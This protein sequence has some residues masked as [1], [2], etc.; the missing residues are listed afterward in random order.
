[1]F[2]NIK[3]EIMKRVLNFKA[4]LAFAFSMLIAG[5]L[6]AQTPIPGYSDGAGGDNYDLAGAAYVTV[7][8][9]I[10][11]YASPDPYFHPAYDP[12][13]GLGLTAGFTWVWSVSV[14]PL[15][16]TLGGTAVNYT[17]ATGNNAG[18]NSTVH[19]VETPPVAWGTCVDAGTNM[20]VNVVAAPSIAY[21]GGLLPS[22]N[23][24]AGDPSLPVAIGT[25]ISGGYQNYRLEWTLVIKTLNA[26]L[27]DNDFYDTDKT[28]TPVP[29]A[30]N[31]TWL[32]PQAVAASGAHNITSVAGG[33]TI[34]D[35]STTVYTYTLNGIN[36]QASRFGDFLTLAAGAGVN[37]ALPN[38]FMH[39][40]TVADVITITVHPAPATGPIYHIVGTWA[41]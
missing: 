37:G 25:V 32:A 34:I 3:Q 6:F 9:T 39:Y 24:C 28:T 40:D 19:V 23:V 38:A 1:L 7:G 13:T 2:N 22:Y 30:E 11:L 14:N 21:A 4:I 16:I 8:K 36:D 5:G 41:L 31:Y 12:A 20:T 15:N 17:Q 10:P 26:D 18:T 27:S 29:I 35:N 33:F